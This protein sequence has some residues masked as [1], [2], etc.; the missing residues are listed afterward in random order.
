[1]RNFA[2]SLFKIRWKTIIETSDN[3]VP[4]LRQQNS[5]FRALAHWIRKKHSEPSDHQQRFCKS[6]E[7]YG[8]LWKVFHY[9]T[10]SAGE[11][12]SR[13]KVMWTNMVSRV[14][15]VRRWNPAC[16]RINLVLQEN[17]SNNQRNQERPP[18]VPLSQSPGPRYH[19]IPHQ[20][21]L[22]RTNY[23][24]FHDTPSS[25]QTKTDI[26]IKRNSLTAWRDRIHDE[27]VV[28]P[29]L[30]SYHIEFR[31]MRVRTADKT[32]LISEVCFWKGRETIAWNSSTRFH[33][34]RIRRDEATAATAA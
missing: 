28:L 29:E 6:H 32:R 3:T 26:N 22:L 8:I 2:L 17:Q 15:T 25:P 9:C 20:L 27:K 30:T 19:T 31:R 23:A 11:S 10:F 33:S 18:Q 34:S 12:V 7:A 1:M 5:V 13:R 14:K 21:D 24:H 4:I 16:A